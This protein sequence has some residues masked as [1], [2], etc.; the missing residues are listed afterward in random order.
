MLANLHRVGI[1]ADGSVA[2]RILD[3]YDFYV[4]IVLIKLLRTIVPWRL[5]VS[6]VLYY[7]LLVMKMQNY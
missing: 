1:H 6:K 3:R 2:I 4:L 5:F 7:F